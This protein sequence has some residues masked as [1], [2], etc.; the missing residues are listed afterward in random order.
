ML[1]APGSTLT[2]DRC[3]KDFRPRLF[4]NRKRLAGEERFVDGCQ[5]FDQRCR[6]V[7]CVRTEALWTISPILISEVG[8]SFLVPSRYNA[9]D[10]WTKV[11]HEWSADEVR[12]LRRRFEITALPSQER[13]PSCRCRNR[14]QCRRWKL[15][16][17]GKPVCGKKPRAIRLSIERRSL[18]T[19]LTA[20][21]EKG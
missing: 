16:Y 4:G 12:N 11:E 14:E 15:T 17:V 13:S 8:T 19:S 3:G 20:F 9:C 21:F 6:Q 10:A 5:S 7:E 2:V 18:R 1:S